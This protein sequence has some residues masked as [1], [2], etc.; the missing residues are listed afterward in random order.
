MSVTFTETIGDHD[1]PSD[2]ADGGA[3]VPP[4]TLHAVRAFNPWACTVVRE[5]AARRR[6]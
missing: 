1:P 2:A 3:S 4:D 5:N 6:S